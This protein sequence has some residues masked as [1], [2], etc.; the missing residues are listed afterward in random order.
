M[1]GEFHGQRILAGYSPWDC[2]ESDTTEWLN[3]FSLSLLW[4]S[5][6][7]LVVRNQPASVGDVRNVFSP[8]VGRIHCR[9][10]WQPTPVFLPGEVHGQRSLVGYS[11]RGHKESDTTQPC[12]HAHIIKYKYKWGKCEQ[13]QLIILMPVY[14]LCYYT[15]TLLSVLSEGLSVKRIWDFC[16][17]Y[18][19]C[20]SIYNYLKIKSWIETVFKVFSDRAKDLR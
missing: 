1:P 2:K 5:Q 17:I 8:W 4:A 14:L 10:T 20:T 16:F 15:M 9:R 3:T 7:A 13:D 12:M 18:Y 11:P 19:I 6:V